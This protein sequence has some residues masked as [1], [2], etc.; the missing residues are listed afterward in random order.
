MLLETVNLTKV[1][2]VCMLESLRIAIV[3]NSTWNIY[4]FRLGLVRAL[5]ATGHQVF[6]IAPNDG[7]IDKVLATGCQY[8]PLRNLSR[9]GTNPIQDFKLVWELR[10]I[11]KREQ[12]DVALH[13]TIKPNIYGS[14]ACVGLKTHSIATV[15]GLGSSF[16]KKGP[17]RRIVN[18]LYSGAFKRARVVAFQNKEDKQ[19]FE[20]MG[21]VSQQ[22]T[23]QIRGSGIKTDYFRPLPKTKESSNFIFL[24]VGRLLY[25]KGVTE[26]LEAAKLCKTKY[27]N[28]EFWLV[29]KIDRDNPSAVD[30]KTIQEYHREGVINYMGVSHDVCSIMRNADCVVLPSYREGLPRVILEGLAMAK[31]I[32][33]TD[34]AGCRETIRDGHNGFMVPVKNVE[35]L[36]QA[37]Q[38]MHA[39]SPKERQ[40][41]GKHGREMALAEFD[42][43]IIIQRYLDIIRRLTNA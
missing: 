40:K 4:N 35:A 20:D 36:T 13:Y 24:F 19:L 26:Y 5:L 14:F 3:L 29:G 18:L 16:L 8:I 42:E 30:S 12:I 15:T 1:L 10:R 31:P 21:L 38:K 22:K 7:F 2:K 34:A 43:P 39:L 23:Q 6:A 17:T 9:K 27:P 32:I 41:M 11:Y 25:D 33:T 28:T 37:M